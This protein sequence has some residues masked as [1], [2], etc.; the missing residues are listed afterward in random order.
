VLG[1]LRAMRVRVD[2]DEHDIARVKLGA[3]GYVT[4]SAFPGRR[5][6]G[7]VVEI[8]VRMGRKNVRTDDPVE[9]LDVKV[10]EVVLQLD[11][12]Q[13]LVSGIRVSGYIEAK[14]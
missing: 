7:K 2:V 5:F 10:L 1:D 4:L 11:E 9:R 13:G 3:R 12:P 14:A 6:P 8:G